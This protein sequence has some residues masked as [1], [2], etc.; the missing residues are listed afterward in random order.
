MGIRHWAF[1][2]LEFEHEGYY[3]PDLYKALWNFTSDRH[4]ALTEWRYAHGYYGEGSQAA[5]GIWI[6]TKEVEKKYALAGL[7]LRW[8]FVWSPAPK[9]GVEGEN[10]PMV[11]K[12]SSRVTLS[13]YLVTDYLNN[14]ATKPLLR[15]LLPIRDKYFYRRKRQK[16]I[17]E[18]R[19]DAEQII[20]DL[21][22]FVSFLPTVR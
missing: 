3:P 1:R 22:E 15:P 5:V 11:S 18:V 12:G 6:G 21:Q 13:G 10:A 4:Y 20:K 17:R 2:D 9:P 7:T 14:W 8:K 19:Q 16:H